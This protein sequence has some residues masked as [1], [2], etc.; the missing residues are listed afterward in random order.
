MQAA[1]ISLEGMIAV[2]AVA[3]PRILVRRLLPQLF[4]HMPHRVR[5]RA[6]LRGKQGKDANQLQ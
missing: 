4:M 1:Q 5:E 3:M 6:L 2:L